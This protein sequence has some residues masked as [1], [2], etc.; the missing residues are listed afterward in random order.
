MHHSKHRD[1]ESKN[2]ITIFRLIAAG[3]RVFSCWSRFILTHRSWISCRSRI[4]TSV[5]AVLFALRSKRKGHSSKKKNRSLWGRKS[6]RARGT[7]IRKSGFCIDESLWTQDSC[8]SCAPNY[9]DS[10]RW[11][12]RKKCLFTTAGSCVEYSVRYNFSGSR[13]CI[14]ESFERGT[15]LL[16]ARPVLCICTMF[17][18]CFYFLTMN[19]ARFV[20]PKNMLW[21]KDGLIF[22]CARFGRT[23]WRKYADFVLGCNDLEASHGTKLCPEAFPP[24]SKTRHRS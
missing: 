18:R 13:T 24:S 3:S 20:C 17:E 9:V 23:L 12:R 21:V 2:L 22:A 11:M 19:L 1:A 14:L 16:H 8:W 4:F 6:I 5:V 15:C 7:N 10:M